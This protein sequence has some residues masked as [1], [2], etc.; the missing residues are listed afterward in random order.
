MR[1]NKE[2]MARYRHNIYVCFLLCTG[3]CCL[4]FRRVQRFAIV[5]S[6]YATRFR[7]L[8]FP[9]VILHFDTGYCISLSFFAIFSYLLSLLEVRNPLLERVVVFACFRF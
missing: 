7:L 4:F 3:D 9:Y 6:A 1:Q 2:K 8:T 5:W